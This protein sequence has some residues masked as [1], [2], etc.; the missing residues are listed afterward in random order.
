[1]SAKRTTVTIETELHEK[2]TKMAAENRR[3]FNNQLLFLIEQG[4]KKVEEQ[5]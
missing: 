1:M 4:I 2:I 3:T 5:Q